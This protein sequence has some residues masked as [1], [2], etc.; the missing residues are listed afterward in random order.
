MVVD[1]K[2]AELDEKNNESAVPDRTDNNSV[3]DAGGGEAGS[4]STEA[5]RTPAKP[6]AAQDRPAPSAGN[7]RESAHSLVDGEEG[8]LWEMTCRNDPDLQQKSKPVSV[9]STRRSVTKPPSIPEVPKAG[10]SE[11]ARSPMRRPDSCR[12]HQG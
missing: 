3:E 10:L 2:I 8:Q 4:S 11:S 6:A 12:G 1:A 9:W 5:P 7:H